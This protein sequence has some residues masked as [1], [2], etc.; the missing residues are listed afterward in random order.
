MK[1]SV[2]TETLFYCLFVSLLKV[3]AAL[4]YFLKSSLSLRTMKRRGRSIQMDVR[5]PPLSGTELVKEQWEKKSMRRM[6]SPHV[7]L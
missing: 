3:V 7:C 6:K 4:F 2:L 5:F 1:E